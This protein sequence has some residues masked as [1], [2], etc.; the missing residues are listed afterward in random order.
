MAMNVWAA[1][2]SPRTEYKPKHA[3]WSTQK[4]NI[5]GEFCL[6]LSRPCD[7]GG[8]L[9]NGRDLEERAT[10]NAVAK[11]TSSNGKEPVI[12]VEEAIL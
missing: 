2:T 5:P 4:T 12:D 8:K 3:V 9:T 10:S 6:N 7:Y 11:K 1:A